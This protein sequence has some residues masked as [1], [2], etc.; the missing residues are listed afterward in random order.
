VGGKR[1]RASITTESGTTAAAKE[2]IG[3]S[4]AES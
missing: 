2:K 3:A 4:G 1:N